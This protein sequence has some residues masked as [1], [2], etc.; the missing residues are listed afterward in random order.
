MSNSRVRGSSASYASR[1]KQ[2]DAYDRL[3][4]SVR[5]ALANAAF[6]WA[7]YPIRQRFESGRRTARELVKDIARWDADQI[8]K[9]RGPVWGFKDDKPP[10]RRQR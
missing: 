8:A 1:E 7:P 9:D 2:M 10:K 6:S 3:P 4:A 5:A